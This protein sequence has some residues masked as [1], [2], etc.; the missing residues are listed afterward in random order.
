MKTGDSGSVFRRRMGESE[1]AEEVSSWIRL[2]GLLREQARVMTIVNKQ[3]STLVDPSQGPSSATDVCQEPA[4]HAVHPQQILAYLQMAQ[5]LLY[6]ARERL[7]EVDQEHRDQMLTVARYTAKAERLEIQNS[8]FR[9]KLRERIEE[10][11]SINRMR[12]TRNL[13]MGRAQR[14]VEELH[15]Y[16]HDL[17]RI[18]T[19][20]MSAE[21]RAKRDH[22]R[23]DRAIAAA[24]AVWRGEVGRAANPI[25][26]RSATENCD[27]ANLDLQSGGTVRA[28][29]TLPLGDPP[30]T[31]PNY[32][33]KDEKLTAAFLKQTRKDVAPHLTQAIA[34]SP[35]R[36]NYSA[37][38]LPV[39]AFVCLGAQAPALERAIDLVTCEQIG[40]ERLAPLFIIDSKDFAP[41]RW[42]RIVFE[43]VPPEEERRRIAPDL[44]WT[45]ELLRRA[46]HWHR[47][48]RPQTAICIAPPPPGFVDRLLGVEPI[49]ETSTS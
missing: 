20:S 25:A 3:V 29:E 31:V 17:L 48:W 16:C 49:E 27:M 13:Q 2:D 34:T 45:S 44:D 22:G 40:I 6:D 19:G 8:R 11:S 1:Q 46:G 38:S 18:A 4:C 14:A 26:K 41:L 23:L 5:D 36:W 47:K 37:R 9:R 10:I 43:Y 15:R 21:V 12:I 35:G 32:Q 24:R 28:V 7:A 33:V 30:Q 39:V 42:H